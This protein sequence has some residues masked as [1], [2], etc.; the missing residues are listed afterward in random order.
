[1]KSEIRKT[2][3]ER[4]PKFEMRNF[5]VRNSDLFRPSSFV[6]RH[7]TRAFTL[8]EMLL[9]LAISAIVVAAIG[10][11]FYSALRLRDRTAAALDEVAPL[12]QVL[13]LLRRDLQGAQPP[14]GHLAG[15][16]KN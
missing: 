9:A 2:I 11:V 16:F 7:S 12:H 3:C 13:T 14:S 5:A 10:G 15:D 8:M 1:M 4:D 6:L